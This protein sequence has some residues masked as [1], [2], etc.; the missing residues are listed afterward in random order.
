MVIMATEVVTEVAMEVVVAG[1]ATAVENLMEE[2]DFIIRINFSLIKIKITTTTK[3]RVK[4]ITAREDTMVDMTAMTIVL[5][6][7]C[8]MSITET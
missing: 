4:D 7:T 2:V 1:E 5:E 8:M 6:R 3:D